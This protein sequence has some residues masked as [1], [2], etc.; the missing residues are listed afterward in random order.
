MSIA[1]IS[2]TFIL[3]FAIPKQ[4]ACYEYSLSE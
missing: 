4:Y 3:L 1:P 2:A